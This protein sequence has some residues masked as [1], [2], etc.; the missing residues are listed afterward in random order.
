VSRGGEAGTIGRYADQPE[1]DYIDAAKMAAADPGTAILVRE[2][3]LPVEADGTAPA[4]TREGVETVTKA[5]Q[6]EVQ[7]Q[8]LR[9]TKL[10]QAGDALAEWPAEVGQTADQT[11]E[12]F[13]VSTAS[14]PGG[15]EVI[16]SIIVFHPTGRPKRVASASGSGDVAGD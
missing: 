7:A 11:L 6:S 13:Q 15:A 10:D 8:R 1:Q 9:L 4:I 14:R 2:W 12:R 3:D 16:R 5:A